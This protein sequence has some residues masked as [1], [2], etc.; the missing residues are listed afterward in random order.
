MD[1][2]DLGYWADTEL[3]VTGR[4][5]DVIIKA[6]RNLSPQEIEDVVGAVP[7]VRRGCVA[8][9][10]VADPTLGTER[11]VVVAETRATD[12][13]AQERLRVAVVE[14]VVDAVG[15]PPDTVVIAPPGAVLKTSSGKIQRT[16][17][18]D[19]YLAGTLGRP[20]PSPRRQWLGLLAA[21]LRGALA[22]AVS[23]LGAALF[24]AWVGVLL[25]MTLPPLWAAVR[26]ARRSQSA[27]TAVRRWCRTV[28]R[29]AG[30]GPTV[31]G[32][33]YLPPGRAVYVANHASYVDVIALL[34]TLPVDLRFVAKRELLAAP[35]VGTVLR[36]M[37]HLT[38]ERADVSRSVAAVEPVGAALRAG[39]S[40]C[41]FP[42]GTFVR[43][44][45]LL[46][47]RLGAF[48]SAVESRCP[49]APVA[50]R[51][52]RTV[53]PADTWRL[54]PG[55]IDVT[56]TPPLY[57]EGEGWREMVRLRDAARAAI[58]ASSDER[59]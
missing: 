32:L 15:L 26:L 48:K 24:V 45:G 9:L 4:R 13:A 51:G 23:G 5:K 29:L 53:L 25:A 47:F 30:C 58:A 50:I 1:S 59:G 40:V 41:I 7:D 17:T 35:I 33:P 16:A 44:P 20:R 8:A 57:A 49:V 22:G 54:R 43:R 27:D 12:P 28:L 42:E 56:V 52:T 2:G 11:L 18:R 6:G 19:A 39:A 31:H 46:P 34:A 3:F 10:G 14:R 37:G 55:S 36:K 21:D 38:V